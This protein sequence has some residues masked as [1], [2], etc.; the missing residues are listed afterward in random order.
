MNTAGSWSGAG[1][2]K[3]DMETSC[4]RQQGSAQRWI[5]LC[6]KDKEALN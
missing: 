2:V 6:Q 3:G 5:Q 4:A 1:K